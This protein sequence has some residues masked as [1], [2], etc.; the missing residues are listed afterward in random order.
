MA[1]SL[2]Q[3][4]YENV[5]LFWTTIIGLFI[6]ILSGVY[7]HKFYDMDKYINNNNNDELI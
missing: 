3:Y 6:F 5:G 7:M 4:F 1:R 2:W